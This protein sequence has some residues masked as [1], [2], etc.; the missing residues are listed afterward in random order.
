MRSRPHAHAP[1]VIWSSPKNSK[2][3]TE[4]LR[5]NSKNLKLR[6]EN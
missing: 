2:L 5:L 4:H 3:K 6:S 1:P